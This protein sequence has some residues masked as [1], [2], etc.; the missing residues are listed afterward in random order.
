MK[1]GEDPDQPVIAILVTFGVLSALLVTFAIYLSHLRRQGDPFFASDE[2]RVFQQRQ[3]VTNIRR[4]IAED[5]AA[6]VVNCFSPPILA[7]QN[8]TEQQV[9]ERVTAAIQS[10]SS[11]NGNIEN[12]KCENSR[13]S[14]W[15]FELPCKLKISESFSKVSGGLNLGEMDICKTAIVKSILAATR[16][17]TD[18]AEFPACLAGSILA[19]DVIKSEIEKPVEIQQ[20]NNK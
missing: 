7:G 18:S 12:P 9:T 13:S 19:N 20:I 11:L 3:A 10:I 17:C 8:F 4:G 14:H 15:T 6:A 2:F 16:S 1:S 5:F